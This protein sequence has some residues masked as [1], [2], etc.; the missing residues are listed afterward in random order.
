MVSVLLLPFLWCKVNVLVTYLDALYLITCL[1]ESASVVGHI[2]LYH[3]S[4]RLRTSRCQ[5]I[6]CWV[7]LSKRLSSS[8]DHWRLLSVDDDWSIHPYWGELELEAIDSK[9]HLT[10][11]F[12]IEDCW[13]YLSEILKIVRSCA[14]WTQHWTDHNND[15]EW[16][17]TFGSF[18]RL[19]SPVSTFFSVLDF[20]LFILIL[21]A[22]IVS[23]RRQFR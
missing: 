9:D 19:R 7:C 2:Y 20:I 5:T 6:L 1:I 22:G 4:L 16:C 12:C 10:M 8:Q 23:G 15:I 14:Q 3:H 21:V 17:Y 18:Y 13:K 11:F